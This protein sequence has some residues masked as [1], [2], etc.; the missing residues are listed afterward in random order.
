LDLVFISL[1][2]IVTLLTI[3]FGIRVLLADK[4][5]KI[6]RS[7]AIFALFISLWVLVDFSLYQIWLSNYQTFLNRLDLVIIS[8]MILAMAYFST[9]FPKYFP[10]I[11]RWITILAVFISLIVILLILFSNKIIVSAWMEDYGSNFK[12]GSLFFLF[13]IL[14][15]ISGLY[16]AIVL[17]LKY[18]RFKEDRDQIKYLFYGIGVLFVF[19]MLF[20]IFIP[21]FTHS[22]R[23]GRL[24]TYS[25]IFL[26]SF[27]AY[28]ILKTH[29]FNLRIILTES[30]VVI[31]DV[32]LAV[33]IFTSH[34]TMEALLRALFAVCVFY[35]SYILVRSVRREIQ[36][37][38]ELQ[39][40]TEQLAHA[41]AHLKELDA[42]KTEFVSLASH[43]LLTPVSAIEGYLSMLLDE[44]MAKLED[45]K[46]IKY[47]TNVYSSA[48]RLARLIADM[49]NISRIEEGRL[50][51][52]KKEIDL[53]ELV[54]QAID[55]IK[56]KAEEKKQRIVFA[57]SQISNLKSQTNSNDQN[58]NELNAQKSETNSEIP[59][60]VRD[61]DYVTYGDADKIKE[62]IINLIGNSIKYSK[63]PGTI[64][65]RIE[66]VPTAWV[67]EKWQ[68]IEDDIKKRPLDDQEAIHSAVDEHFR[69]FVGQTQLMISV[70]DQGIGIP[71]EELPRLFKKFHRVGDYTTAESQGTGLGLYISRALVELHHGRIWADSEGEGKGS[72]F[73]FSL[74]D[75]AAKEELL[76]ME[77]QA[78]IKK[79]QLKPLARPVKEAEEI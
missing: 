35:G 19:N 1:T 66:K 4:N 33:Q 15:V 29:L 49:L 55:E 65:V 2:G 77:A 42:M 75:I 34:S 8:F 21:M 28:A 47:M 58:Q 6:N 12:Q 78:D 50:L 46:A 51:V 44:K 64:V 52:E 39:V 23:Y 38:Q 13:A 54:K 45:P 36:F 72:T 16:C 3:I 18:F 53:S 25:S 74:P 22:F 70:K 30:A 37:R 17:L 14:Q 31:I 59:R 73:T 61:D 27:I 11:P 63:N 67:K 20:N 26:V 24:G 69:N 48:K 10:R 32:I 9:L 56:F 68:K 5:S 40:M 79:D 76:K 71:K 62:V 43:E 57:K 60:S 7:F 41:N